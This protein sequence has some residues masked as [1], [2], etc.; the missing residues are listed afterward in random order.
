MQ[1]YSSRGFAWVLQACPRLA[2]CRE[3]SSARVVLAPEGSE[4]TL[5]PLTLRPLALIMMMMM[6]VIV[7]VI[8]KISIN[9]RY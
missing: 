6:V 3:V 2:I 9:I 1:L 4:V 7:I 8:I 5:A